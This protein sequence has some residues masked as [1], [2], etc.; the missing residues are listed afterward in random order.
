LIVCL[1][2]KIQVYDGFRP[3]LI[4]IRIIIATFSFK[5]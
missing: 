2:H 3:V 4:W 5:I 1:A